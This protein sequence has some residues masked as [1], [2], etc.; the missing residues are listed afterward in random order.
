VISAAL[1]TFL[2][3]I[4]L[5]GML[6]YTV[7]QRTR[8]IGVRMALGADI[9]DV[10]RMIL[11]QLAGMFVAGGSAGILI[12]LALGRVA[13]SLLFGLESYDPAVLATA[14]A[15]LALVTLGAGILPAYRASRI[16]PIRALHL[17]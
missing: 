11:G 1:A 16:D 14:P 6:T 10:R 17:D 4:G 15:L 5:Y 2:A 12:A 8:E 7:A 9:G 3:A 13:Q